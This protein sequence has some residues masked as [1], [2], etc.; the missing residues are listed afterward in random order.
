ML[1]YGQTFSALESIYALPIF[2]ADREGFFSREGINFRSVLVPGGGERMIAA[3]DDGSVDITHVAT[4][5]LV[6]AVLDG[7]DAVAILAEFNNPIYSLVANSEIHGF[8]DLKGHVIGLAEADGP[9]AFATRK[10]LRLHGIGPADIQVKTVSGTPARLDCLKR[11]AC[12]AVPLGQPQDLMAIADGY[13]LLGRSNDAVPSFLYT[14]TAVRRGWASNHTA[15][16]IGY[17]RAL[18]SSFRFIHDPA[19]RAAVINIVADTTGASPATARATLALYLDPDSHVLPQC[20]EIDLNGLRQVIADMIEG[21][22]IE[23]PPPAPGRF[24]DLRYLD[25]A[26]SKNQ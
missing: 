18:A 8:A 6:K 24:V 5:Y 19:Q 20:G 14:V 3:L 1:R 22:V 9:V 7:A 26:A 15:A 23:G 4:S 13:H 10:L 21:G 25:A 11:G 16:L 17:V 12:D 2:V